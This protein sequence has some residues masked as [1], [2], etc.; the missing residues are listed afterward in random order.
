MVETA[1]DST[2][3]LEVLIT[4]PRN[5][6]LAVLGFL[7]SGVAILVIVV[8]LYL[9]SFSRWDPF[10]GAPTILVGL[11]LLTFGVF[12]GIR[13]LRSQ[14]LTITSEG[15]AIQVFFLHWMASE[16]FLRY[17]DLEKI[18]ILRKP[19]IIL[20]RGRYTITLHLRNQ[21]RCR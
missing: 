19:G 21:Q 1:S 16:T 9:R 2:E 17:S 15:F 10:R 11:F 14:K 18:E 12:I 6:L 8:Q 7:G 13:S 4:N 20:Y 3:D 5:N